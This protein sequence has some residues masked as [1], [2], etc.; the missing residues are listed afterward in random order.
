MTSRYEI[1]KKFKQYV[2]K[3]DTRPA[4]EI[5][6]TSSNGFQLQTQQLFLR[7]YMKVYPNW[8]N[9]LLYHEIGSG[10]TCTAITMAE[11]YL[12]T[13]PN[14]K[15][16]VILPARLRTNFIDEL[17][18]PCA[19]NIYI[20]KE[21]YQLFY[22]SST[23]LS[24]KK[25]IKTNFMKAISEKYE[26]LS[27][28]RVKINAM[29]YKPFLKTWAE[30]FSKN[31]M[32]IIDEVHNLLSD[33]YE[34]TKAND[35]VSKGVMDPNVKHIKGMNTILFRLLSTHSHPTS[36]FALLTATPI[37]DNLSQIKEL[38]KVMD[39]TV[40]L[41]RRLSLKDALEYLRGK[42][43]YFPGTS[44]NAYP[45]VEYIT[46]EIPFSKLQDK[47]SKRIQET[48]EDDL[49]EFKESFLVKQ[50]QVSLACLPGNEAVKN[51]I[52]KVLSNTKEYCPK[53]EKLISIIQSSSGKH[54]IYSNF[55]QSGLRIIEEYLS[56]KGWVSLNE[57][58]HNPMI[59]EKHK[60]KV[61]ALWD[62]SVKD[63]DKQIIKNIVNNRDNIYGDK[64]RVILGSP[65]VKEGVSFKHMQYLHLMDPVWNSSA[66]H[67]IEGRAIRYCSHI[68]I[69]EQQHKPLK[70]KVIINIYK[71]IP[72]VGG[73]VLKT[74]D[75][76]I[77]DRII[78]RKKEFV[79]KGEKYLKKIAIDHYL[80][81]RMYADKT[82][83]SPTSPKSSAKSNISIN[84]EDDIIIGKRRRANAV[85]NTCP[86]KRRP[87]PIK[88]QCQSGMN[89]MK[90]KYGDDCCYKIKR[91]RKQSN[92][93]LTGCPKPRQ[94]I[95]GE[96]QDGFYV[97]KNK[98]GIECCYKK[99]KKMLRN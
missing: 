46:H 13:H 51:D 36:K 38:I 64:V 17:I 1:Y 60:G 16:K 84:E 20:S 83:K 93:K 73:Q 94:P 41:P 90:N 74:C 23:P 40:D 21:D 95:N 39:P 85:K 70:R 22:S 68:D 37:F 57:N 55:I 29:K 72:I 71:S 44:I 59:F 77:Y 11:E 15:V 26:I 96:C 34:V 48:S 42:V 12:R 79:Q 89:K 69:D 50:R 97:K 91:E 88:D 25:K 10:K 92:T 3:K 67:Q 43:S 56:R 75:Q 9:L 6:K 18:S 30:E 28:E 5:C 61:Y 32:I 76:E 81:R 82:P 47:I 62:G 86:K 45:S 87:D 49:D 27:F 65:S 33:S 2:Q 53:I 24:I 35:L 52:A 99:T 54:L 19:M 98:S 14:N 63:V 78:E 7:E 8:K 66:K 80:F 31:S 58:F 4:E